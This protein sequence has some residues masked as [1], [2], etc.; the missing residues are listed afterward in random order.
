MEEILMGD[1]ES[2]EQLHDLPPSCVLIYRLVEQHGPATHGDLL[3][4]EPYI[5]GRTLRDGL[6]R[7]KEEGLIEPSPSLSD[8][9]ADLYRVVDD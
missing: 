8:P 9:R 1:A 5:A 4:A 6:R 3:E 7:L 2:V